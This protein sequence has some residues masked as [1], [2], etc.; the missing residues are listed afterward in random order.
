MSTLIEYM[1]GVL[2]EPVP[3]AVEIEAPTEAAPS[4]IASCGNL[5]SFA[6]EQLH[7]LVRQLFISGPSKKSR[8]I[9]FSAVDD[10]T[11][12]AELCR[13]VGET[14]AQR[15]SGTTCVIEAL[16][17]RS[18]A[19]VCAINSCSRPKKTFGV[20]RDASQQ[21]SSR[22]WFMPREVMLEGHG[23]NFSAQWLHRRL[24]ELR[25]EF[26]SAVLYGPAVGAHDGAA[27]L[28]SLCDGVVLVLRA[29]KTR[30][31]AALKVK[32]KLRLANVRVFGAILSERT[33]PIP[34]AIYHRL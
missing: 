33:F 24:A 8:Q 30:R 26:D 2:D 22:L 27:L 4:P 15:D 5:A 19:D 14:L 23:D 31:Q 29:N 7:G 32:E 6:E 17:L 25:L 21:L 11:D 10:G 9:L 13:A 34:E 18:S 12:L 16:P 1:P 28:G 3:R 20:L